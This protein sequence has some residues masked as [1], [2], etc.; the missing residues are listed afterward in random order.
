MAILIMMVLPV[1]PI[2]L[3]LG[4]TASFAFAVLIFVTVLFVERPLDFSSFPAILL[5]SLLLR[6]ALNISSTKLIIGEGHTGTSAAG[7]VIEGFAMFVMGGNIA[8]GLIVFSVLI[9]VNFLVITKGAGRMAEVGARFALDAMPGK[10]LAIDADVASG[11][12]THEEAKTLRT[13][14]QQETAF[15]GSLDGVSK[16]VKG[17]AV[18]SL[19]VTLLN[20]V[21]GIAVGML[22]HGISFGEAIEN[23]SI[24]TVGDGLVNQIPAVVISVAAALLLSKGRGEEA[25]DLALLR[26][27]GGR[28]ETLVTVGVAMAA[29]A[30]FPGLP[31][32]PFSLAAGSLL[33]AAWRM[34]STVDMAE[35]APQA[36]EA[37]KTNLG[38]LLDVDEVH[39]E[40]APD[41]VSTVAGGEGAFDGRV[42]KIRR[43]IVQE[44]GFILPPVRVTDRASLKPST[45]AIKLQGTEVASANLRAGEWLVLVPEGQHP[46]IEGASAKEPVY[47]AAARW[48]NFAGKERAIVAGLTVVEPAEVMATHLLE[49]VQ[50]NFS[51]LMTRRTLRAI[52]DSYRDVSDPEKAEANRRFLDEMIPE[53]VSK[54]Q[55]LQVLRDLLNERVSIRQLPL[56]I[57]AAAEAKGAELPTN[58]TIEHVRRRIAFGFVA[59]LAGEG[60]ELPTLQLGD[61][62]SEALREAAMD[63]DV[64]G[65]QL[66]KAAREALDKAAE[67]GAFPVFAVAAPLRRRLRDILAVYGIKN[68]VLSL[69]EIRGHAT[70]KLLGTV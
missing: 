56:I 14:E 5:V 27:L 16:F 2:V 3:D 17:D 49:T 23:Y 9:I 43:F 31:F 28:R 40:I 53:R 32:L 41:L 69:D 57:E 11:A 30:M 54:D 42:D 50:S 64:D 34:K 52:L 15:L 36:E 67:G 20:L 37:P 70:P 29:F 62:W 61:S 22:M 26:E 18:A 24:L 65:L 1:P 58:E 47:G 63:G 45:Y 60:K 33:F 10:Q 7:G 59:K 13:R 4:L 46:E 21:A 48:V 51:R 25:V 55:L 66:A 19:L 8:I 38:D 6:L 35:I 68:A 12:I 44:Y 39:V